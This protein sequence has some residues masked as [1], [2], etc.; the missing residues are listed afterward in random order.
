MSQGGKQQGYIA[1]LAVLIL[2]AASTAIAVTLLITGVD[3]QRV[4][5]VGENSMQ[6]RN[7][8]TACVEEALQQMHDNTSY[9][10]SGNLTLGAGTCTYTV[11]NT[12]GTNRNILASG[13]VGSVV[14]KLQVSATAGPS[15]ISASSWQDYSS[16]SSV[17][18]VQTTGI[19]D[20][21]G[22][23]TST[24]SFG[25]NTAAGNLIVASVTWDPNG[26]T[27]TTATCSDDRGN[28]YT[29]VN[30]WIDSTNT[31]YLVICYAANI[32]GG[33]TTLTVTYGN[34]TKTVAFRRVIISEYSG[35]V[36]S[37]PVDVSTGVGGVNGTTGTDAITSGAA[38]TTQAGDL[39][40]GAVEDTGLETTITAGT[41]FVQRLALNANDLAV[42]DL[43]QPTAGS[44]AS[45]QTFASAQRYDAAMVAFK[46]VP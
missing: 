6:A 38:T 30:T 21:P 35:V 1:L 26:T 29:T 37:S 10:G 27:A 36:T 7:L 43:V 20:G 17:A 13:T 4:A 3:S 22:T 23:G 2:G 31:Q 18:H 46:A 19:V 44:I 42:Q 34:G 33:A 39:I 12:G 24:V 25:S 32:S 28:S 11:T 15:A 9:T 14:R 8:A 5:L 41:G 40:Y 45:T 16:S